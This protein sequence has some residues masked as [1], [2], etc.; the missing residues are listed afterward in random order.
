MLLKFAYE[1]F[2]AGRTFKKHERNIR[3]YRQLLYPF[4]EYCL[5]QGFK[6]CGFFPL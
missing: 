5:Q 4:I 2:I 1:D 6:G 3:N